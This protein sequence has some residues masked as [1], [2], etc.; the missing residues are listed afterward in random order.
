M[1][2][3]IIIT[4]LVCKSLRLDCSIKPVRKVS[5]ASLRA[6]IAIDCNCKSSLIPCIISLTTL[7]NGNLWISNL[8]LLWYFQISF[9]TFSPLLH[10][11]IFSPSVLSFPIFTFF[12]SFFPFISL[13]LL[14][15]SF[16]RHSCSA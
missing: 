5:P 12:S 2:F 3:G 1:S 15:F 13:T 10:L 8:V 6:I 14:S 16:L 4:H 11:F 7:C 9:N